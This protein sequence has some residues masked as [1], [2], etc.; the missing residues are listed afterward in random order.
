MNKRFVTVISMLSI[1]TMGTIGSSLMA[2]NATHHN[3][4]NHSTTDG[5]KIRGRDIA[6]NAPLTTISGVLEEKDAEWYLKS[7][8][9]TYS[10]HIGN[11][12]YRDSTGIKLEPGKNASVKGFTKNTDVAVASI[13]MDNQ[14]YRFRD[15]NGRPLWAGKG[16]RRNHVN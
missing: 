8:S 3:A 5:D 7:G 10:L 4:F 12:E 9:T 13:T 6:N 15:D 14:E 16:N 11:H 2:E 1:F